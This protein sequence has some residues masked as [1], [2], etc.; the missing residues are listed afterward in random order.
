MKKSAFNL[1]WLLISAIALNAQN[2]KIVNKFPVDGEG[3]WDYLASDAKTGRLFIS[4]G[5][6]VNVIDE[7]NGA[8]VGTIPDTKGVHGIAIADDLNKGFISNGRDSS[9]TV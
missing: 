2:Y 3:G 6:V 5:T 7:K 8:L 4:H 1:A 9:V